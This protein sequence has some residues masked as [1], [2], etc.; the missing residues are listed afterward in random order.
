MPSGASA[1]V[2]AGTSVGVEREA[3]PRHEREEVTG[4]EVLGGHKGREAA[5][6]AKPGEQTRANKTYEQLQTRVKKG[7]LRA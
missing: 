2:T 7:Y 1:P 6:Q 3:S 5:N 4:Q